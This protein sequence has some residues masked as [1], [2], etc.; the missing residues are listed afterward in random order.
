[1]KL[2]SGNPKKANF[3]YANK[4]ITSIDIDHITTSRKA[5]HKVLLEKYLSANGEINFNF[6]RMGRILK[7]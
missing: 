4:E 5:L 3:I 2:I 1:M 6:D 7:T